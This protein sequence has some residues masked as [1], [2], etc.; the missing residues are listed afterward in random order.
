MI[1]YKI[2]I[3]EG[4]LKLIDFGIS[5]I[6]ENRTSTIAGTPIYMA[7]EIIL[8]KCY[9]FCIDFWSIAVCMYE[10]FCGCVPFGEC[11]DDPL[12]IYT[13][14]LNDEIIF[15]KYVYDNEFKDLILSLL[16][17]NTLSRFSNL[18][19]IKAHKWFECFDWVI[20]IYT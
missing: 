5:K 13:S 9:A 10:F 18:N 4:Y 19:Q 14:I 12:D 20:N 17:R 16:D 8:G 7:P 3:L 6:I 15:P 1:F 11:M 2:K